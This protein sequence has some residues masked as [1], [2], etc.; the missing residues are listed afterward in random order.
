MPLTDKLCG[1]ALKLGTKGCTCG[2]HGVLSQHA[3]QDGRHQLLDG[4][5]RRVDCG[6]VLGEVQTETQHQ[7]LHPHTIVFNYN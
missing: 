3:V 2:G 5:G 7:R 4:G 1:P 6:R